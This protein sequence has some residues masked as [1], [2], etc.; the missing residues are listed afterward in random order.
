MEGALRSQVVNPIYVCY[1]TGGNYER[2]AAELVESLAR[3]NLA[4]DV[5]QKPDTG[6]WAHNCAMKPQFIAEM[7][8]R[9]PGRPLVYLDADARVRR[10]P[11]LLHAMAPGVD[12]ACHYLDKSELLSGTLYI[13]GTIGAVELVQAWHE[14]CRNN[15]DVWDQR[16][17]QDTVAAGDW[18][19]EYLPESYCRIFD[20]QKPMSPDQIVIEHLQE[21]RNQRR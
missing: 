14:R 11:D 16:H 13:G 15:P 9:Y 12:L 8:E 17:L 2:H 4:Y 5:W 19:I 20:R 3:L 7:Q 18:T 10:R 1:H 21:S 6:K